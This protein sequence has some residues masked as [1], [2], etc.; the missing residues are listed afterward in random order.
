MDARQL[1]EEL[2][3]LEQK[4]R[5]D[6]AKVRNYAQLG[7]T[8]RG[9]KA[10]L[11]PGQREKDGSQVPVSAFVETLEYSRIF[12]EAHLA[13]DN[14]RRI[15]VDIGLGCYLELDLDEAADVVRNLEDFHKTRENASRE[16]LLS[17]QQQL[18]R[19][20]RLKQS[21]VLQ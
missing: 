7:A 10:Q 16:Q 21:Y 6:E 1:Q 20:L 14:L 4:Q 19:H 8:I 13:P 17:C 2:G 5:S 9:I 18:W 12:V 3:R 11:L 15:C